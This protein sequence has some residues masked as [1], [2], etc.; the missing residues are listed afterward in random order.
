MSAADLLDSWPAVQRLGPALPSVPIFDPVGL[1]PDALRAWICDIAAR[2]QCPI[3]IP[4][5]SAMV[6]LGAVVGRQCGIRPKRYDTTWTVIPNLWGMAVA[7]P[8]QLKTHALQEPKKPLGA[9]IQTARAD[10]ARSRE[11]YDLAAVDYKAQHEALESRLKKAYKAQRL[12]EAARVRAERATLKGKEPKAPTERRYETNDPTVEKLGQLLNENPNGLL[13]FRD[14]LSGWLRTLDRDGHENDRAFYCEAWDGDKSYTYDRIGRGTLYIDHACVSMLG[15]IQPGPLSAF[16]SGAV[17][18]DKKDDDGLVQ[19]FQLAVYPDLP[20]TWA[21]IDRAPDRIAY[22]RAESVITRLADLDADAIGAEVPY[23]G[24]VPTLHFDLDAQELFD[25]WRATLEHR[26]RDPVDDLP[27]IMK[28]HLA[29]FRSMV[30]AVALLIHL[31][32]CA[33]RGSG[34]RV[35]AEAVARAL[36]WTTLLEA[37]ATRIYSTVTAGPDHAAVALAGKLQRGTLASPFRLRQVVRRRWAGLHDPRVVAVA[38]G[39]LEDA[40]WIRTVRIGPTRGGGRP[41]I[42]CYVNPA[43]SGG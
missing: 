16:L 43:V 27:P 38:L 34:G 17:L 26:L 19:R 14:E 25:T 33:D 8:G 13:V 40:G 30:P 3:E 22:E 39:I 36:A 15:G 24:A 21:N 35:S 31:T 37:H 23:E 6:V 18:R 32:D 29:K 20:P 10:Y 41:T 4:A 2:A 5:V 12:D 1:L 28:A 7:P 9:L 42:A 11:A